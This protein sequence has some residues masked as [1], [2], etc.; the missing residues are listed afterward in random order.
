MGK[1]RKGWVFL[2]YHLQV[3]EYYNFM[4]RLGN[5]WVNSG[6]NAGVE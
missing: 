1:S 4:A 5:Q 3:V 6:L 2:F